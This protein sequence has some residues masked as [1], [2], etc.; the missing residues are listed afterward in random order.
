MFETP[1]PLHW[2]KCAL[3]I[4][5]SAVILVF[6]TIRVAERW[7]LGLTAIALLGS[8]AVVGISRHAAFPH[9]KTRSLLRGEARAFASKV[10]L[11]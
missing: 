2:S 5:C 4:I 1:L 10:G 7:M 8:W 3:A 11:V 6:R 9:C